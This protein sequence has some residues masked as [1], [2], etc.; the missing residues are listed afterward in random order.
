MR[1]WIQTHTH[2][3]SLTRELR[4]LIE[5][6]I[7]SSMNGIGKTEWPHSNETVSVSH[8]THKN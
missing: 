6:M 2:G 1:A 5:E 4:I 8:T 3:Q 7:E